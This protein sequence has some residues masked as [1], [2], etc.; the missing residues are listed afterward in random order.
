MQVLKTLILN[1]SGFSIFFLAPSS[2]ALPPLP[3]DPFSDF[4]CHLLHN[5]LF[6][7]IFLLIG[8]IRLLVIQGRSL[9]NQPGIG[10][11]EKKFYL[12]V[13][14]GISGPLVSTALLLSGIVPSWPSTFY[15]AL[16]WLLPPG[17]FWNPC[18]PERG[19][20]VPTPPHNILIMVTSRAWHRRMA[21]LVISF[22]HPDTHRLRDLESFTFSWLPPFTS[23]FFP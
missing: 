18:D 22:I 1:S 23:G 11:N 3:R 17:R 19:R 14:P 8:I 6:D 10:S 16:L 13:S 12:L 9:W 20:V 5:L 2:V 7:T 4:P 15:G 21:S